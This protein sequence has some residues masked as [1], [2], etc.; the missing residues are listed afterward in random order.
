MRLRF[1]GAPITEGDEPEIATQPADIG[2][3]SEALR[4]LEEVLP[5][6]GWGW[7][8]ARFPDGTFGLQVAR[9]KVPADTK[10]ETWPYKNLFTERGRKAKKVIMTVV[11]ELRSAQPE[12]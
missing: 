7:G 11:D 10:R 9:N 8:L 2:G 6:D 5:A 12:E 4:L 1:Q 3:V